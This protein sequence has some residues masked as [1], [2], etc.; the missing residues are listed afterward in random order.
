MNPLKIHAAMVAL[1][2]CL[3]SACAPA[4]PAS[5][6]SSKAEPAAAASHS[7]EIAM[8][9]AFLAEPN[10]ET[11]R[12]AMRF[13][14]NSPDVTVVVRQGLVPAGDH[15]L[16]IVGFMAGNARAQL[17]AGKNQDAPLEGVRGM[18]ETYKRLQRQDPK[19]RSGLLDELGALDQPAL[20]SRVNEIASEPI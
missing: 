11:G 9:E 13:V 12:K 5:S 18:L 3:L 15:E 7:E 10:K 19:V 17:I 1:G 8:L 2:F 20:E 4:V 16:L 6:A 14:M